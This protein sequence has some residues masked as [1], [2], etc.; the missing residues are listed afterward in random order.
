ME[1]VP[2]FYALVLFIFV[3]LG[4][5]NSPDHYVRLEEK[6]KIS[7]FCNNTATNAVVT[8]KKKKNLEGK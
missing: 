8:K 1:A 2:V 3:F 6:K 4:S 7:P 5:N